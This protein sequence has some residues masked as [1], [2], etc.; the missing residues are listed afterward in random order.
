MDIASRDQLAMPSC[1]LCRFWRRQK[2][3]KLTDWGECRRMPPLLPPIEEDKL[4]H[5]GL[6]PH[7]FKGDWCGE[8]QDTNGPFRPTASPAETANLFSP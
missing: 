5:V 6:W 8:W 2:D 1:G 4:I 7:T 3:A